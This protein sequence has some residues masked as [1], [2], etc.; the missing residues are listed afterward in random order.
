MAEVWDE[1][2]KVA[3]VFLD[4]LLA[5]LLLKL[6]EIKTKQTC[7]SYNEWNGPRTLYAGHIGPRP[8]EAAQLD[9]PWWWLDRGSIM[10]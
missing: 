4:G 10:K 1:H 8:S 6:F 7:L 2:I 5:E 9:R 3:V